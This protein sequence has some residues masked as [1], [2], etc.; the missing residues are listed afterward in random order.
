MFIL[1]FVILLIYLMARNGKESFGFPFSKLTQTPQPPRIVHS[2]PAPYCSNCL[3]SPVPCPI[4]CQYVC[5]TCKYDFPVP[6]FG[7]DAGAYSPNKWCPG[8]PLC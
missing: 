5:E 6:V 3:G 2:L 7:P 1:V 8:P 4:P